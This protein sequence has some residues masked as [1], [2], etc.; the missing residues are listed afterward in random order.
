MLKNI[1]K[2]LCSKLDEILDARILDA[3]NALEATMESLDSESKSSAGDKHETGREMILIE[4]GKHQD[5]LDKYIKLKK[6]ISQIDASRKSQAV[7]LGSLVKTSQGNY[8][9]SVGLGSIELHGEKYFAI[10]LVSPI[11]QS[12]EGL[13]A[14]SKVSFQNKDIHILEVY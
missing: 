4:I 6:A 2:E 11:G 14:G 12:L 9:V 8:F 3:K 10:S 13:E 1:K 7:T 5:L